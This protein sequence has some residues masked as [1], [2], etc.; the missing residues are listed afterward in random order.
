MGEREGAGGT[1]E[2][3][4][5][6]CGEMKWGAERR[7]AGAGAGA[8]GQWE[9]SEAGGCGRDPYLVPS[10]LCRWRSEQDSLRQAQRELRRAF[11]RPRVAPTR[12]P[13]H[14]LRQRGPLLGSGLCRGPPHPHDRLI[15]FA[16]GPHT[17]SRLLFGGLRFLLLRRRLR[18]L[19]LKLRR[20]RTVR[21]V[22]RHRL[23]RRKRWRCWR[24]L[25]L[26]RSGR[27]SNRGLLGDRPPLLLCRRLLLILRQ[28]WA[29]DSGCAPLQP[30]YVHRGCRRLSLPLAPPPL[31]GYAAARSF[32]H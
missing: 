4:W 1:R 18:L 6:Q 3:T 2:Q 14:L 28:F 29:E 15:R 27:R 24:L 8:G 12:G 25:R 9:L 20:H 21:L 17:G 19:P 31:L 26:W 16:E 5:V 7:G 10:R 32:T 22:F 30:V 13:C 11:A 23:R